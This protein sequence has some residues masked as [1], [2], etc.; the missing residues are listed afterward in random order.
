M[1]L[2]Y[3]LDSLERQGVVAPEQIA[4]VREFVRESQIK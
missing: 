1:T 3:L 4:T 2:S